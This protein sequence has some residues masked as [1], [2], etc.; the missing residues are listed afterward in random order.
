MCFCSS[1]FG[2]IQVFNDWFSVQVSG[3]IDEV[4][5]PE[6]HREHDPG[7]AVDLTDAV[8]GLL[9]LLGLGFCCVFVGLVQAT[10]G[11]GGQ[12]RVFRDVGCVVSHGHSVGVVFLHDSGF[13][14]LQ[15]KC[16]TVRKT[17]DPSI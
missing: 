7:D 3:P 11:N 6:K 4:K 15:G 17:G 8:E 5:T 2:R 14:F 9:V 1:S 12:R 10:L 16:H 13:F